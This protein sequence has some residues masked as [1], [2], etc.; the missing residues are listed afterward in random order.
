MALYFEDVCCGLFKEI[1]SVLFG[2]TERAVT[3]SPQG[4]WFTGRIIFCNV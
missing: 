4:I 2:G 1:F 3:R